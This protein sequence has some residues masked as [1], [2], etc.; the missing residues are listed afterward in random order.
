MKI[1][2]IFGGQDYEEQAA[3][4]VAR[5]AGC[6]LATA[7]V[8]GEPVHTGNAYRADGFKVDEGDLAT[9][10]RIAIF[11]CS[12]AVAGDLK[13]VA[14]CDHH[15]P[16]D[17]GY[18]LGAD[19]YWEASSLGQLCS[20]FGAERTHELELVA[21]G[22]HCPADAY[23]GRCEGIDPVEFLNFRIAGKVAF[24]ATNP[25]T[26]DKADAEKI[27]AA[28]T[29]AKQKLADAELV[30]GVR[31]LREAGMIDEL[32]EAALSIGEVYMASLPDTD[33]DRN[34]TGNTKYILGGHTT[35]ETVTRFME[36][37]NLLP[38]RVGD[39]Y[40]NPTRGFAGVI[41]KG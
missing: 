14:R 23:A 40:G 13:V 30:D 18:G 10:E 3:R 21:A 2:V 7:T 25:H 27:R 37:G 32:P 34:P 8:G 28:I 33:R 26:A 1:M 19:Q 22:D 6:V 4:E 35:P 36:W 31:D 20:L 41:V 29:V 15:N 11:E 17:H 9:V 24:Y 39:A 16:G 38:N 12:S 5:Q